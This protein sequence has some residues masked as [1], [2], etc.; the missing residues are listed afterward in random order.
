MELLKERKE[1]QSYLNRARKG[2]GSGEKKREELR[3]VK[4]ERY[5]G[6]EARQILFLEEEWWYLSPFASLSLFKY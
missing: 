6:V 1:I 2:S 3:E 5:S 4:L